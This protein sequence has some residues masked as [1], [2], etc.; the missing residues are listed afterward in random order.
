MTQKRQDTD[1]LIVDTTNN[2]QLYY[3]PSSIEKDDFKIRLAAITRG[4]SN[5]KYRWFS[6]KKLILIV[7]DYV[8]EAN[9]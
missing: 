4:R 8:G 2:D 9:V 1:W 6:E 5:V 7:S 3:F